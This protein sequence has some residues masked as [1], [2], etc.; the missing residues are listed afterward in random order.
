MTALETM[1]H[2]RDVELCSM[3]RLEKQKHHITHGR[4]TSVLSTPCLDT[5]T[6]TPQANGMR[7]APNVSV[8]FHAC[9]FTQFSSIYAVQAIAAI[10]RTGHTQKEDEKKIK[11]RKYSQLQPGCAMGTAI[12]LLVVVRGGAPPAAAAASVS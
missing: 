7:S 12:L 10:T 9:R 5:H 3:L 4:G 8:S 6:F 11:R 2:A 1:I